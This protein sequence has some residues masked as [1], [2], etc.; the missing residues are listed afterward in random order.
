MAIVRI[1]TGDVTTAWRADGPPDGPPVLMAHAL[2]TD[3]RIWD[4]QVP[5]LADRY[6]VL[7]Y[8]WRGHGQTEATPG[9][10]SLEMFVADA[11]AL[12]DSLGLDRVHW[13]GLS[14]GGMIGQGMAILEPQR[15]SSLTLCNTTSQADDGYRESVARREQ[16]V[17][18]EGM[19]AAWTM[20]DRLWFTEPFIAGGSAG[21]LSVRNAFVRIPVPGYLA[22]TSA[23]T[24]LAWRDRLHRITAPTRIIAAGED[25]VTPPECS[26]ELHRHIAGS[27]LS[28]IPGVRHLSNV[29]TPVAFNRIL[30][31]G[32]DRMT[33]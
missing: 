12:L 5:A 10:W 32:L 30:R 14:T 33:V 19:E 21:Y 2:G 16:V 17:L 20:V 28:V 15:I 4:R 29:E 22:A 18:G 27:R 3:H 31:A 7:R 9:S 1:R 11:V 6:R 8:D 23:V 13:V 25:R 24:R 26:R